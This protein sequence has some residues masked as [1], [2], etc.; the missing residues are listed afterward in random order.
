MRLLMYCRSEKANWFYRMKRVVCG[1]ELMNPWRVHKFWLELQIKA[2][3]NCRDWM[4]L[5]L[6]T[7]IL[8][9]TPQALTIAENISYP[10]STHPVLTKHGYSHRC[11]ADLTLL[12]TFPSMQRLVGLLYYEIHY[13]IG[14]AGRA[15][16]V[17][18]QNFP[19]MY[20]AMMGSLQFTAL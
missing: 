5:C 17:G 11:P 20:I 15:A 13:S 3:R 16:V 12:S 10:W 19:G 2:R 4:N 1:S 6:P 14:N 9:Y 7:L 18:C 8:K